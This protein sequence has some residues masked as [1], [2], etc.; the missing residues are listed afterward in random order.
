MNKNEE[1][2]VTIEDI[3]NDGEGIGHIEGMTVFVKDAALLDVVRVKII[4]LKKNYCY[5]RLM[6]IIT[7]SAFRVN[8]L[9]E[10]AR[11][12]GGC[13]LMHLDYAKQLEYKQNK[14]IGCLERIGGIRDVGRLLDVCCG[15]ENPVHYRNK[16]QFPVGLNRDGK[17]VIGFYAGRTHSIIDTDVC[18]TGHPVNDYIIGEVKTLFQREVE[19]DKSLIYNE[20]LHTGLIR[21]LLT[22][23]GFATGELMV[24][25]VING[26]DIR[27]IEGAFV[28]AVSAAVDK[29][30]KACNSKIVLKSLSININ[31]DRTNKILGDTC[32]AIYGLP[33]IT[34]YIDDVKYNISPLSFYQVNPVQTQ[35]LYGKALEY[36]GLTGGELVWDM[37]C[38]IGTIS[39]FLA[40]RARHVYGVEIIPQAIED[41][42]RNAKINSIENATFYVGKAEEVVPRLFEE[43]AEH[44]HPDVIV[45]DPPRKGMDAELIN[46]I[47]DM[48]PERLVYVSCDPATLGRDIKILTQKG[49]SLEKFSV[50]DQFCHSTHVETVCLL[51][52]KCPV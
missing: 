11:R 21:H 47:V 14:V 39:L 6:E 30:N 28:D 51:S 12:C 33:Y 43:G 37:Y 5:A 23:V 3:G 36:A 38:G 29:Y 42:R 44:S 7:P 1:Y 26:T 31:T 4:K 18:L 10:N 32:K 27:K 2:I 40:K 41:A 8:P 13:S 48:S 22:R 34:D 19:K 50:Y 17:V 25:L 24:C 35:R 9:C 16:M 20:E 15:M 49:F 52:K 46:T 45:V